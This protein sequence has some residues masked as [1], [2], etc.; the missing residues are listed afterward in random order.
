MFWSHTAWIW[1]ELGVR[2]ALALLPSLTASCQELPGGEGVCVRCVRQSWLLAPGDFTTIFPWAVEMLFLSKMFRSILKLN[3]QVTYYGIIEILLAIEIVLDVQLDAILKFSKL[4]L[5]IFPCWTCCGKEQY[6][7]ILYCLK[8][9]ADGH[10]F[11]W[12]RAWSQGLTLQFV[13]LTAQWVLQSNL[14]L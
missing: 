14:Q 7:C 6:M 12:A 11:H 9:C 5:K 4:G 2:W 1:A 13:I 10:S 8:T 3:F